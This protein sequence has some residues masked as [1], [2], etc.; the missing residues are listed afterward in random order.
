MFQSAQWFQRC[1]LKEMKKYRIWGIQD[2]GHMTLTFYDHY[3]FFKVHLVYC[4]NQLW[5]RR[6]Q[7]NHK[8]PQFAFFSP[9]KNLKGQIWPCRKIGQVQSRIIIWINE[10]GKQGKQFCFLVFKFTGHSVPEKKIFKG[11]FLIIYRHGGHL[12]SCDLDLINKLSLP[13]PMKA[14]HEIRFQST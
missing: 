6:L 10:I 2:T 7:Q 3:F 1:H 14:P 11:F 9:Y 13:H 12:W 5:C 8:N 4:T